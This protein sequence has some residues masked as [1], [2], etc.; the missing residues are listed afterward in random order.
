MAVRD[1]LKLALP[2]LP[3]LPAVAVLP[4]LLRFAIDLHGGGM[5]LLRRFLLGAVSPSLDPQ[6]LSSLFR[7]LQVTLVTALLAWCL[8]CVAGVVL[9]LFSS[10]TVWRLIQG[11]PAPALGMRRLL[12]PVRSLHELLWGLL[13]LQL[14]GLNGWVAIIAIA[15][16]YA[17]LMARVV[18]DLIDSRQHPGLPALR[19]I[20]AGTAST[21]LTALMP[22]VGV[23][24]CS[25]M[26][27][28]LE[29]ALRSALLIGVFGLGGLGTD[30]QLSLQSLQF[31]DLW[32]GLWLLA[33]VMAGLEALVRRSRAG[34]VLLL[35][36][37]APPAAVAWGSALAMDLSMP[38]LMLPALASSPAAVITALWE[39]L[40]RAPWPEL[41][42][43]TLA[44]TLLAAAVAIAGPP[45]GVLI[46][47]GRGTQLLRLVWGMLRLFPP[48]LIAL[49]LLL[50]AQPSLAVAALALG[51][52]HLG[53]MGRVLEEDLH[54][55][56]DATL[57]AMLAIGASR[58]AAWLYGP[59]AG[60]SRGYLA[61]AAYRADVILRDTAVVGLV[62]GAGLGWQLI[63]ALSSFDWAL[64]AWLIAAYA[65]LTGLGE[66]VSDH[67]QQHWACE[68]DS[69]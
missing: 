66:R 54:G 5:E 32:S 41:L 3:L 29:C 7:S 9:G 44:L 25:H 39:A 19:C 30:L 20:G 51:L 15:V 33:A 50:A 61:Y 62:G 37:L 21:L 59:I 46:W 28:R 47:P 13:L 57:Q 58:H 16:P 49:L 4:L 10:T 55:Q 11:S 18:S 12:M 64:V 24:L 68:A 23:A 2:V 42:S 27:H 45:L 56:G 31:Q 35:L 6:L 53:V 60:C 65:V 40:F 67:L 22:S 69:L 48:P 8:S 17:A 26:A 63:E 52:H 43:S 1:R 38:Q 14:F 36:L 34:A